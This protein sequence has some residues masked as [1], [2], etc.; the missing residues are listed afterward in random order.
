MP[1]FFVKEE[2]IQENQIIILGQDVNHIKKVL[3]AKIG[4]ELQICNSQNGENFLCEIDN[5]EEEKI[6]CQIKEKIQEQVES[7]IEVTIF[8][9]LPKADK[10]EYI[11]QKSVELGVYDITPVEMKRCVVKLNEKDKSKKIERWQKISEVAAKQCG[12]DIIPQ[13]NNIINIKNICNL[14]QEYDMVLVAYENEEKNTLKEQ[15]ENIKKQNNSKSK[16]KIG[17]IIGP[18]GG[19][20]EK[21]VETLKENGAKVITLGRRILRTETVALNVLSI[22]MYELEN[23]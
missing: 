23:E 17:I 12:R 16:V 8:Q 14:I 1:K 18:E 11:I 20:E 6:I 4:D 7:N 10:M 13:I 9:G 5:L 2:Q 22:I 15:L 19:L 3:R 21:D